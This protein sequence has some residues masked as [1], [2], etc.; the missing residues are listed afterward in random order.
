[1]LEVVLVP[2]IL[3]LQWKVLTLVLAA[4]AGLHLLDGQIVAL[5]GIGH[6]QDLSCQKLP[7]LGED[8]LGEKTSDL[9]PVSQGLGGSG[10]QP[11][12]GV[13]SNEG[14]VE[15]ESD[16]VHCPGLQHVELQGN[17]DPV[18]ISLVRGLRRRKQIM[19]GLL[20]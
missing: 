1:M 14:H 16:P 5:L 17:L 7:L 12:G 11:D 20:S 10:A 19:S 15:P 9:I 2:S 6:H 13:S 18:K 4:T 8:G 3:H